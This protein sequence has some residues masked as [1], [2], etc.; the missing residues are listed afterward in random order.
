VL[1]NDEDKA[2]IKY[3]KLHQFKECGSWRILMKFS[4]RNWRREGLDTLLK[5]FGKQEAA[6]KG[7]RSAD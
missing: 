2:L 5:I 6:T 3:K 4:E 1:L 7:M